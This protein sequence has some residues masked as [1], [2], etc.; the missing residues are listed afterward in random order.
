MSKYSTSNPPA[1]G[2]SL[3][4]S[5]F[6]L[7]ISINI[8]SPS[9]PLVQTNSMSNNWGAKPRDLKNELSF[10]T[11]S[12]M[13]E[14]DGSG[15]A[16]GLVLISS[17]LLFSY[18]LF[19][20]VLSS[21]ES[22]CYLVCIVMVLIKLCIWVEHC[23][24]S[25]GLFEIGFK[26]DNLSMKFGHQSLEIDL[27]CV[28]QIVLTRLKFKPLDCPS[29][30]RYARMHIQQRLVQDFSYSTKCRGDHCI[31][32]RGS[33]FVHLSRL[34]RSK[35]SFHQALNLILELDEA[36]VRLGGQGDGGQIS[37]C[38]AVVEESGCGPLRLYM[39]VLL[40]LWCQGGEIEYVRRP[41]QWKELSKETS[42]KILPCG[43]RSCWKTFK[44]IASLIV[45]EI[46]INAGAFSSFHRQYGVG[47]KRY[48]IVPYRELNGI[49]V[50]LVDRFGVISKS[51]DKIRVSHGG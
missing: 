41:S 51:T 36:T 50:A 4:E 49:P 30:H 29:L 34:H 8:T 6:F 27:T 18:S 1:S 13:N 47:S 3:R 10:R 45:K 40:G 38:R 24:S 32:I 43:D 7:T 25:V 16:E 42:S 12:V 31:F 22:L 23:E 26:L 35:M 46:E 11:F 44:L 37:Y 20:S 19:S 17:R 9:S 21:W 33:D 14:I 39:V 5:S 15:G 28:H 48:H 2:S